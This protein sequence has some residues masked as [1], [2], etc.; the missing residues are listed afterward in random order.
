MTRINLIH[1]HELCDKHLMA[2]YRELIR[3]PNAVFSE[4]MKTRYADAPKKY[5]LGTG[6]VKFFVDKL[7][8]LHERHDSLFCELCYRDFNVTMMTWENRLLDFFE[9]NNL[10]NDFTPSPEEVTINLERIVERLPKNAR[11]TH[12]EEPFYV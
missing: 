6:H 7:R 9:E 8:W 12:R 2:E 11:W 4:R 1:P 10:Y 5:T 3:I